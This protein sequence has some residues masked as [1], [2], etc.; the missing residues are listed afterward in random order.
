MVGKY[1]PYPN[2]KASGIEWLGDVPEGWRVEKLGNIFDITSSKRI[3]ESQ[4]QSKGIPFYRARELVRLKNDSKYKNELFIDH[5]LYESLKLSYGVPKEGDILVTAVGTLGITYLVNSKASFYFKDG[6]IIWLRSKKVSNS[7]YV[8]YCYETNVIKIQIDMD[9][10]ITTVGTYTIIN[11]KKNIVPF[12]SLAEQQQIADFLDREVG[13]IEALIAKQE[14]LVELLTE[15]R[16]AV[17]SHAVTKGLNPTHPMKPSA[18]DW[19]G[20]VPEHWEVTLVKYSCYLKGRVG[21]KGLT[22][23]EYQEDSFAYL[24]TGT[25]FKNKYIQWSTCY[26]V[27][28]YRYKDDPY[29]QLKE[30]DLLMTKDGTIGKLAIVKDLNKAACLNSGIFL[31]R[32]HPLYKTEFLYWIF[33]SDIFKFFIDLNSNGSTILHLYQNVFENF[34]FASPPLAEQQQITNFLDQETKKIDSLIKKS[35]QMVTLLKE[36]KTALISA[37]VTGKIDVRN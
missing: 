14:R 29:I 7:R 23:D 36:R 28:E 12:P 34:P 31:I 5:G 21:W 37:A 35:Q 22:S 24:V 6:N 3:F 17:I 4:W 9:N 18:I 10:Y 16:Q 1:K 33:L 8:V 13:K 15:K 11:A 30:D 32:P 26:Q 20:N 25:D 19:L 27:N 2:Y